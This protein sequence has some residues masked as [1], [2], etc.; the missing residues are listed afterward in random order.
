M[1]VKHGRDLIMLPYRRLVIGSGALVLALAL[2]LFSRSPTPS[3]LAIPDT[4]A[5]TPQVFSQLATHLEGQRP[6]E[7]DRLLDALQ[8]AIDRDP[9]QMIDALDQSGG[10]AQKAYTIAMVAADRTDTL[11]R[12]AYLVLSGGDPQAS[13]LTALAVSESRDGG[14]WYSLA[15]A[16]GT[17]IGEIGA[18]I[19]QAPE[20]GAGFL[21][22]ATALQTEPPHDQGRLYQW[23]F[24]ATTTHDGTR[25]QSGALQAFGLSYDKATQDSVLMR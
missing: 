21:T 18:A 4:A 15:D 25:L 2:A 6:A 5:I 8:A 20:R 11:G 19:G 22:L 9:A 7:R 17:F 3:M 12:Q 16:A 10:A 24:D 14:L 1:Q 23:L 13:P